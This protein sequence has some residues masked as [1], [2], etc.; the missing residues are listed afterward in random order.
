MFQY[1]GFLKW[2]VL[3]NHLSQSLWY[4]NPRWLGGPPWLKIHPTWPCLLYGL[5]VSLRL[6]FSLGFLGLSTLYEAPDGHHVLSL[7]RAGILRSSHWSIMINQ[8]SVYTY[9]YI[10]IQHRLREFRS[11]TSDLWTDA[12]TVS[13]RRR[14]RARR[15][16][17][18]IERRSRPE[19]R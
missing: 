16:R 11:Q 6:R 13:N 3:R 14:Q 18:S 5:R 1:G 15:E 4:W 17:V 9:V 7:R 10:Y 8:M 12:A 19:K 2:G